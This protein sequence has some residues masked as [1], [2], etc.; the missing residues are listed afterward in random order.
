LRKEVTSKK[1]IKVG[2]IEP[3]KQEK[4]RRRKKEVL[5]SNGEE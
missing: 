3:K 4:M 2:K 5:F 1:I